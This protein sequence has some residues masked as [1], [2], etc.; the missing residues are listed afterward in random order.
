MAPPAAEPGSEQPEQQIVRIFP[1]SPEA[2]S[3]LCLQLLRTAEAR[4]LGVEYEGAPPGFLA[5]D[6]ALHAVLDYLQACDGLM[7]EGAVASLFELRA[8]IHDLKEGRH[9]ALL[10]PHSRDGRPAT[11]GAKAAIIG[12]AAR[13]MTELVESG[14][15]VPAAADAV[16]RALKKGRAIGWREV[17]PVTVKNWRARCEAG[18]GSDIAEK[19]ILHYV[20]P[21]LPGM[22]DTPAR[23]AENLLTILAEAQVR[24]FGE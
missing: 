4:R 6:A 3:Q 20:G 24:G 13:A 15:P 10:K 1:P 2:W 16:C 7:R 22:G 21:L 12:I 14:I 18:P 9:P 17:K 5:A 23:R 11:R 8:A 19:A